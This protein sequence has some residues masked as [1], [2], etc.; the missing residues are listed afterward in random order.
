MA[1]MESKNQTSGSGGSWWGGFVNMVKTQAETVVNV[2]KEDLQEFTKTIKDDTKDVIQKT[3]ASEE[4]I[5]SQITTGISGLLGLQQGKGSKGSKDATVIAADRHHSRLL[6]LQSELSTFC[7]D[8]TDAEE[9]AEWQKTFAINEKT[10]EISRLLTSNEKTREIHT[11]VVPLAV[12]YNDFWTRYY[13]KAHKLEQEEERRLALM[14]RAAASSTAD[15][16]EIGWDDE[17]DEA[18]IPDT[19]DSASAKSAPEPVEVERYMESM[20]SKPEDATPAES[21]TAEAAPEV[22]AV[23]PSADADPV[24]AP[25]LHESVASEPAA[26]AADVSSTQVA[27][28]SPASKPATAVPEP[29]AAD[30]PAAPTNK[31]EQPEDWDSWE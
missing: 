8:P 23:A 24:A 15:E 22:P 25:V 12:T 5:A 7:T 11:K 4:N 17:T 9:Y 1:L 3:A 30:P 14:K 2:Y 19:A 28:A 10:D 18:D 6:G 31:T 29:D 13:F 26:S 21:L 27:D 20:D 16:L